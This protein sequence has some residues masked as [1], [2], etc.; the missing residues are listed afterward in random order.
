VSLNK[1]LVMEEK[2]PIQIHFID[3]VAAVNQ[4][5]IKE[6]NIIADFGCGAG[7]FSIPVAEK[8]GKEGRV[9]SLDVL[10]QALESVESKARVAGLT[11]ITTKRVNLENKEGSGL[12]QASIDWVIIKDILFQNNGK[13]KI[14][15]EAYRVLKP[16]GKA[17][18]MEWDN[19]NLSVGPEAKLRV[20]KDELASLIKKHKFLVEKEIAVGDFH[21]AMIIKK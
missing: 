7:Y 4:L 10:T 17:L 20:S 18:V 16:E 2:N 5:E 15:A 11:N 13:D 1:T 9:Y 14:L 3:P 12:N 8:V 6:G 19:K 21:Y